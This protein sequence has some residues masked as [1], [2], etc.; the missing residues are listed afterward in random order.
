MKQE[1]CN[2][3]GCS[4]HLGSGL[5]VN[6]IADLNEIE[7]RIEMDKPYP[8]GDFICSLCEEDINQLFTDVRN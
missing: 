2:E 5:F 1:I 3:C 4:V 7:T 8:E 6:R